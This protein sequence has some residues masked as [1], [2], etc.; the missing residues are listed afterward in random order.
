MLDYPVSGA[1]RTAASDAYLPQGFGRLP[2]NFTKPARRYLYVGHLEAVKRVDLI[3][4]ALCLAQERLPSDWHFDIVGAGPLE[5]NLRALT[6]RLKL[7]AHITFHG[8]VQWGEE[9]TRCYL[10]ADVVLMAST[11]EGASRTLIEAMAFGLPVISTRVGTAPDLLIESS[12]V[13]V[14]DTNAYALCLAEIVND[15]VC[16]N[17]LSEHNWN[18]SQEFHQSTLEAIRSDFWSQ[19]IAASKKELNSK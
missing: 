13:P 9:I 3:I 11:T 1:L 10:N 4:E 14:G 2:R 8:R 5:Q 19:A 15:I 7:N 12:I 18:R 6:A 16:L 17:A